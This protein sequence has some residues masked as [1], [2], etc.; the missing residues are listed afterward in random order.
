MGIIKT[1]RE[2]KL[3]KKS[4][5]IA[6]SCIPIIKQSLKEYKITE[7]EIVRRIRKNLKRQN[8]TFS[9]PTIIACGKRSAKIHASPRSTNKIISGIGLVDFGA[10]YKGYK[11]DVTVPFVKGKISKRERKMVN[12]VIASYRFAVRSIKIGMPCWKIHEKTD[13]FLK[14][15]GFTIKHPIGHGL[16]LKVHEMPYIGRPKKKLRGRK[17]RLWEKAKKITFQNNMIFTIEPGVYVK[18]MGGSRLENDILIE[19]KRI[20]ILTDAKLIEV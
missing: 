16:G 20:K 8:A 11:S 18:G 6:N 19:N 5:E 4:A 10:S 13:N 15:R 17:K 7:K 3:L 1:R 12:A 2:I 9:F 14:K